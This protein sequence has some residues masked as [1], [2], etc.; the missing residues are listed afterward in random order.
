MAGKTVELTV[1]GMSCSHCV[2]SVQKA[3][4]KLSGIERAEIDLQGKRVRVDYEPE[5]VNLQAIKDAIENQG[6]QVS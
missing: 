5:A 3:L 6:F 4:D 2:A 1:E